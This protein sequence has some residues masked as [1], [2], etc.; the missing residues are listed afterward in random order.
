MVYSVIGVIYFILM[1]LWFMFFKIV[2]LGYI[3]DFLYS[4]LE[5]NRFIGY[6]L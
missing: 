2:R 4:N 3:Y 1:N 5:F 6:M